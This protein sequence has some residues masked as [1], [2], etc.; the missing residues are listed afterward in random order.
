M[1][2][3]LKKF[4]MNLVQ[5][6]TKMFCICKRINEMY[7]FPNYYLQVVIGCIWF[8]Y[9]FFYYFSQ[10]PMNSHGDLLLQEKEKV[11]NKILNTTTVG[12]SF[13]KSHAVSIFHRL[14][15]C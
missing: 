6:C 7:K 13:V 1:L 2:G 5:S 14:K 3:C 15:L 10:N 4:E 9:V 11:H 8:Q 12:K